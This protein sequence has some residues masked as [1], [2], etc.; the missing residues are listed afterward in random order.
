M[1]VI[2]P[3]EETFYRERGVDA[4]FVGHPSRRAATARDLPRSLRRPARPR[5]RQD[6]DRPPARQ[7]LERDPRQPPALHELAMSDLIAT[8]AAETPST[9]T[10]PHP[11]DP[12][13]TP[14]TSS[15]S[16]S[17][18][19]SNRRL[20]L[21]QRPQPRAP[22][23]LWPKLNHPF[24]S[25]A[26]RPRSPPSRPRLRRRQRHSHRPGRHHRQPLRRRLPGLTAH[27][28]PRQTPRPLSRRVP[29]HDRRR[30][31]PARRH[32]Q[33]HRRPP[34]RPRAP[35]ATTSP[36]KR[37]RRPRPAA[38]RHPRAPRPDR[39][40]RRAPHSLLPREPRLAPGHSLRSSRVADI[41]VDLS[42]PR[43]AVT[44]SPNTQLRLNLKTHSRRTSTSAVAVA[45]GCVFSECAEDRHASPASIASLGPSAL[46]SVDLPCRGLH[47]RFRDRRHPRAPADQH[48]RLRHQRRPRPGHRP[49]HRDRRRHLHRAR[50]PHQRHLRPQ[51]RP[52]D[53]QAHRRRGQAL[54][55][56]AHRRRLH[57]PRHAS[58]PRSPRAPPPPGPSSTTAPSRVDTSPVEGIKL[59]AIADPISI[60]LYPGRWFPIPTGLFTDRFTAEIH[61]TRPRR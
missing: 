31:Q 1:L 25:R 15:C 53:H 45:I 38:R 11:V 21:H 6:L 10:I 52:A 23:I 20:R 59:A 30:R 55:L 44:R 24:N 34:H 60:L 39:R 9:A 22:Q 12:A 48:H 18:P 5:P 41:V 32:G 50:R 43:P 3:F 61:I 47:S 19:P 26:R 51:Q 56:R 7:P 17:P 8:A 58:P 37:R 36:P 2:F 49:P 14:A 46:A 4:E 13:A 16:Q 35:P 54:T 57:R 29:R 27:L 40:P 42:T 33:P 28:R